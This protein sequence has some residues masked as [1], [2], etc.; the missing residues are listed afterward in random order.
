MS[1]QFESPVLPIATSA[2]QLFE[3]RAPTEIIITI[4]FYEDAEG[5]KPLGEAAAGSRDVVVTTERVW[6]SDGVDPPQTRSCS[7]PNGTYT[8]DGGVP[9]V[10]GLGDGESRVWISATTNAAPS[11]VASHYRIEVLA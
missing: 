6:R 10:I 7:V 1:E 2:A 8:A 9:Q 5:R 3:L 4:R 11:P